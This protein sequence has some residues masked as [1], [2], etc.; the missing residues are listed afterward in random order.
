MHQ[1]LDPFLDPLGNSPEATFSDFL[2]SKW[3]RLEA[4]IFPKL[5]LESRSVKSLK[6]I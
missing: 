3:C 5:V 2:I 4:K 1:N 6:C